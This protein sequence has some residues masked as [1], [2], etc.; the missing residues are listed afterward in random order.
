[1]PDVCFVCHTSDGPMRAM[2]CQWGAC[3]TPASDM[4]C[5]RV[6]LLFTLVLVIAVTTAIFV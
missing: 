1:M 3:T 6:C 5:T 4:V 2:P